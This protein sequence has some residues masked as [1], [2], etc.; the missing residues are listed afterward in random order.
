MPGDLHDGN[1]LSDASFPD[2]LYSN[3][4]FDEVNYDVLTIGIN[5]RQT[6]VSLLTT[7]NHH[8]GNHELYLTSVAYETFSNFSKFWGEKYVTSNVQ[9]INPA[10][11]N[12]EY[13]GNP[14]YYFTTEHGKLDVSNPLRES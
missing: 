14:Y 5:L 10:T 6:N 4:I 7:T 11:G 13:I 1:G 12:F 2:G 3:P 9:I 8:A